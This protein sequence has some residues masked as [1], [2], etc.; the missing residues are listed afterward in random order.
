VARGGD[1]LLQRYELPTR[2]GR[3]EDRKQTQPRVVRRRHDDARA[4]VRCVVD[5]PGAVVALRAL[6]LYEGVSSFLCVGAVWMV[7]VRRGGDFAGGFWS[8][9]YF[10]CQNAAIPTICT[11]LAMFLTIT[12]LEILILYSTSGFQQPA[13]KATDPLALATPGRPRGSLC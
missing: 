8:N 6:E 7:L 1:D 2:R 5:E 11:F 12:A 4:G 10:G 13:P 9:F 3:R